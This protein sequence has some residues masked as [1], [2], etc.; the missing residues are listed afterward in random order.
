MIACL[1]ALALRQAQ[2][3]AATGFL[4]MPFNSA[5]GITLHYRLLAS[6]NPAAASHPPLLMIAGMASDSFSW[7]PLV[8]PLSKHRR[9][10]LPDNRC[11][12]QTTPSPVH[13]N[14]DLMVADLLALLDSLELEKVSVLG[15][16]M[17]GMLAW[18]L[19]C[20]APERVSHLI[21]AAALPTVLPARISLFNSLAAIRSDKTES[22]W[23][24]LLYHFLFQADFFASPAQVKATIAASRSYPFKQSSEAF[25]HQV[26]ALPSFT[27][28]LELERVNCPI[29]VMTG[30]MDVLLPPALLD[31]FCQQH[32]HIQAHV[33]TQAAHALHREQADAMVQCVLGGLSRR[34]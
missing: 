24:E 3:A 7:Q 18:A 12:G 17:G 1:P 14:R 8:E 4:F 9:L 23:F 5:N 34:L 21:T 13:V 22:E 16:S 32:P 25:K 10:I 28:P 30:D 27:P 33:I 2:T 31:A 19:A 15:H 11:T 6:D 29:T 26:S 20:T